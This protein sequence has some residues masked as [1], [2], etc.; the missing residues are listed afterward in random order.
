[1]YWEGCGGVPELDGADPL[2]PC[3][4]ESGKS[5]FRTTVAPTRRVSSRSRGS[6]YLIWGMMS[7]SDCS[8]A[9]DSRWGPTRSRRTGRRAIKRLSQA[10]FSCSRACLARYHASDRGAL[11][12]WTSF[13]RQLSGLDVSKGRRAKDRR[14]WYVL[15]VRPWILVAHSI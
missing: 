9:K 3:S 5:A 8:R 11:A 2:A 6:G 12:A 1:M 10:A 4:P 7:A 15:H 14:R 13:T